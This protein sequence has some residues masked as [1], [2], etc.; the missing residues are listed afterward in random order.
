METLD[1]VW[2]AGQCLLAWFIGYGAGVSI[3]SY[4]KFFKSAVD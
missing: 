3:V 2:A 1:Y 4:K